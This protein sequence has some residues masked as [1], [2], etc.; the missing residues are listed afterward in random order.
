M[1]SDYYFAPGEAD[2]SEQREQNVSLRTPESLRGWRGAPGLPERGNRL[3]FK[4]NEP[5]YN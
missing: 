5:L 3:N 2:T 4:L 1:S